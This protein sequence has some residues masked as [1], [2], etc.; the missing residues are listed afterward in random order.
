MTYKLRRELVDGKV[1]RLSLGIAEVDG[2]LKFL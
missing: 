1:T 2:Y